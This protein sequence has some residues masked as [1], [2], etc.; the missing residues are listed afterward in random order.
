M[1]TLLLKKLNVRLISIIIPLLSI[2]FIVSCANSITEQPDVT[3]YVDPYIGT[4]NYGHTFMGANV[5]F[6]F[7]QLGPTNIH[8]DWYRCSG[9]YFPDSTI[10]GFSH[11]HL[12]GTGNGE[13]GDISL[14]PV[15][16]DVRIAR[17]QLPDP[18][19]GIYSFFR[20]ET[21][22]S[23][24]GYYAVHLD[25]FNVDVELTATKRVGFHK[26][27]FIDNKDS[28]IVI[29]LESG[30]HDSPVEGYIVQ[31]NDSVISG[32]RYSSGWASDQ[33]VYFT[34]I[35]SKPI[36]KFIVSEG[37]DFKDSCELKGVRVYGQAWFDIK[38]GEDVLVKVALS[39]V[40]IENAKLNMKAELPKWNFQATVKSAYRAWNEELSKIIISTPNE[41]V[42]QIFYTALYHTMIAPSE[43]ND[44]NFDYRGSDKQIYRRASFK[45][46][47][48]F[49][50]W[51]TYRAAHPLMTIIH[52]EKMKDM[53]NTLLAVYREQ[54]NLPLFPLMS[55]EVW[56]MVG[57]PGISV[58]ADALLKNFEG[59]DK[60]EAYTAMKNSALLNDRGQDLYKQYGYIPFDL[61][62]TPY[63]ALSKSMEYAIADWSV[64]QVALK[65]GKKEDYELFMKRSKSYVHYFD[66]ET[67]F[68]RP[69]DSKGKFLTPFNPF[70]GVG[71]YYTEG[72]AWQYSF[73]VPHDVRGLVR[74]FGGEKKFAE[75]LDSLFVAESKSMEISPD[76]TGVVGQYV[77][78]N[79]PCHHVIYMYPYIGQTWKTA[80][81][82]REIL[83]TMY[84]DT[85]EGLYGNDDCGQMSA[86]YILSA[87]GIYQVE[88]AGGKY[89][90]GS[91]IV[92]KAVINVGE[93]KTFTI[94]T[95]NNSSKNK[96][97]KSVRLNG[98]L[99][100]KYYIDFNDIKKGGTIEFIMSDKHS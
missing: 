79:E 17:G 28:R 97:I 7:V 89:I 61:N 87:L 36:T 73:L 56:S 60:E 63:A 49:S 90:F 12:S 22:K 11:T 98:K 83:S 14:M 77:H 78:G 2:L 23:L 91:P 13:L 51:D 59:F 53:I 96:Y 80:E 19:T 44:I 38:K 34:A 18:A 76:M 72:N 16:G 40:S 69:L 37:D 54:G 81:K 41:K 1:K 52:P 50:L 6:G 29:D 94:K 8:Q 42:K 9:Y 58:V 5:P 25:R 62:N 43:C 10:I 30:I 46:Y 74:L 15:T 100:N 82:A 88:P 92:D 35:F 85:P 47:T 86:W 24:A 27:T 68:M 84:D 67:G 31:E 93:G 95:K 32:Y 75:K 71:S 20:H 21:E 26:Y 70:K 4:G 64:A 99:Y 39:P 66:S 48:Y 3:R 55:C 33:Q 65:L 45:N 57:N